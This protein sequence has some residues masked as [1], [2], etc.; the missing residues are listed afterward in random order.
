MLSKLCWTSEVQTFWPKSSCLQHLNNQPRTHLLHCHGYCNSHAVC[1]WREKRGGDRRVQ[2]EACHMHPLPGTSHGGQSKTSAKKTTSSALCR[3]KGGNW[4]G[5]NAGKVGGGG[6]QRRGVLTGYQFGEGRC[7]REVWL[8]AKL[9]LYVCEVFGNETWQTGE[10]V[11]FM[12]H[13]WFTT[14]T[15]QAS[16]KS[17]PVK[18][19]ASYTVAAESINMQT[20]GIQNAWEQESNMWTITLLIMFMRSE[21]ASRTPGMYASIQSFRHLVQ[22]EGLS[23]LKVTQSL[24]SLTS[25]RKFIIK[26][27]SLWDLCL[28]PN[29]SKP[30]TILL[31]STTPPSSTSAIIFTAGNSKD[32]WSKYLSLKI[33]SWPWN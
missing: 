29:M 17:N 31:T 27:T 9:Y 8:Q 1:P 15:L 14:T 5:V 32:V 23:F 18:C 4:G 2:T 19:S 3:G 10:P 11:F 22:E 33:T 13:T 20:D 7:S 25:L 12:N 26:G 28:A 16:Y 6:Q 21:T 24:L 30:Q